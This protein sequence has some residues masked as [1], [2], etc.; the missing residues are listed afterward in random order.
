M[1]ERSISVRLRAEVNQFKSDMAAAGKAASDA[2]AKTETAWDKSSSHMG[3]LMQ[4]AKQNEQA[5]NTAGGVLTAAGGSIVALGV[6]ATKSGI[7]FNSLNQTAKGALTA[8]MGSAAGAARQMEKMNEFGRGTWVM[9]DSLIRAQQTMTGFGVS[10]QKVIPYMEALAE[11]VA[12][13]TGSNQDFEELAR[14]MGKVQSSGKI[15][16]E[17]FNEFGTRGVDAAKLI[18]DAMGMTAQ[19]V[20]D[21]VTKGTLDAGDALDALA[22]GMKSRFDGATENMRQTFSGAFANVYAGFR[23]LSASLAE[24]LVSKDGGGL[25]VDGFNTLA[26]SLNQL[27]DVSEQIP[28]PVKIAVGAVSGIGAVASLAAGGF[29]LLAPRILETQQAFRTL[30][31]Q[32]DLIGKAAQGMGK[33]GPAMASVAK[34]GAVV[35][36][37]SGMGVALAS[38][39]DRKDLEKMASSTRD[40][41]AALAGLDESGDSLD[42]LFQM[43]DGSNLTGD[44]DSLGAA[45]DRTFNRSTAQKFNDWAEAGIQSFTG[46][47]GST[48]K[49]AD[50]LALLDEEMARLVEGGKADEAARLFQLMQ[51]QSGLSADEMHRLSVL[52]PEYEAALEAAG[53]AAEDAAGGVS[54]ISAEAVEAQEQLGEMFDQLYASSQGFVDFAEKAVDAD[55][56]MRDWIKSMEDQVVAQETWHENLQKLIDR[57]APQQLIDHFIEL[58]SEGAFRVKQ[59]ADGSDEDLKRAG[60]AFEAVSEQAAGFAGAITQIPDINLEADDTTLRSQLW[61]AEQALD[62]LHR[63]E[64]T[65]ETDLKITALEENIRVAKDQLGDL[66]SEEAHPLVGVSGADE[67]KGKIENVHEALL[68]IPDETAPK[69]DVDDTPARSTMESLWTWIRGKTIWFKTDAQKTQS[70]ELNPDGRSGSS[71]RFASGGAIRGPGSGTSDDIIARLSNGEHV[72]TAEE[73]RRMG[74]HSEVYRWRSAVMSGDMQAFA[75]GGA[76]SSA[77]DRLSQAERDLERIQNRGKPKPSKSDREREADRKSVV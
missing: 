74:G 2:A 63:M 57:G 62:E 35:G 43:R 73:V 69:V 13:T 52:V 41:A 10:T 3:K 29:L 66:D 38:I 54:S 64:P 39:V 1:A 51:E 56:S 26:D 40:V 37:I 21:S 44:V 24:P 75:A 65:P 31:G 53:G 15:T 67:S 76:V 68:D 46:I 5:W 42:R 33:L 27:R 8:V 60:D 12:A 77:K 61:F 20:R 17:T 9:R 22:E 19:E 49:V 23:D 30:A 11:T 32:N 25:L 71:G 70:S 72:L 59:L 34:A 28:G 50:Q 48:G 55:V 14:V 45:L 36:V 58:G 47:R 7:E 4:S 16:A 18:G 6:A